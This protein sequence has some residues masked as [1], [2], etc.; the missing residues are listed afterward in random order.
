M[1]LGVVLSLNLLF[2]EE[3][4]PDCLTALLEITNFESTVG[5]YVAAAVQKP[6]LQTNQLP[7][8]ILIDKYTELS[9]IF[10]L[11]TYTCH[12]FHLPSQGLKGEK[13]VL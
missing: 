2:N 9:L 6:R 5:M 7:V 3:M 12:S 13:R 8:I 10:F 1:I 4:T 11:Q